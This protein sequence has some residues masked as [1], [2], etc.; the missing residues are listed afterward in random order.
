[1]DEAPGFSAFP[2]EIIALQIIP[3]KL[4]R[5]RVEQMPGTYE[6]EGRVC[7]TE[8]SDVED[9]HESTSLDQDVARDEVTVRHEIGRLLGK[10]P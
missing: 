1:L 7:R 6:V 9:P 4:P 10:I 3:K 2:F 5:A 8:T